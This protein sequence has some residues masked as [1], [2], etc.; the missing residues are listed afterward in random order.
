[1]IVT[2]L[3]RPLAESR[4]RQRYHSDHLAV[5]RRY[6]ELRPKSESISEVFKGGAQQRNH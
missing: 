5:T 6:E 3:P 2:R 1:M 4:S